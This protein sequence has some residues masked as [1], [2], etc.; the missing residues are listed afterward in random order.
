MARRVRKLRREQDVTFVS[1]PGWQLLMASHC[2]RK[3]IKGLKRV[4]FP[5]E[6][7]WSHHTI[8]R[9]IDH[10]INRLS[11]LSKYHHLPNMTS[12]KVLIT[13]ATGYM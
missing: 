7:E 13:G 3:G 4:R 10:S 11:S 12:T 9:A 8:E 2:Q 1:L 6:D 5:W